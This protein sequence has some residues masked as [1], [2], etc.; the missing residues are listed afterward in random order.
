VQR[1]LDIESTKYGSNSSKKSDK[2]EGISSSYSF[3]SEI[4]F[5]SFSAVKAGGM[6]I[7]QHKS[8]HGH[9]AGKDP[10]EV[11]GELKPLSL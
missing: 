6:R 1:N 10:V 7:V 8:G 9:Q 11:I 5:N 2:H 4:L 3:T